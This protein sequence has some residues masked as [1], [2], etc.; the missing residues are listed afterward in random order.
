M[1]GYFE[2]GIA[3]STARTYNAGISKYVDLC[4]K[5]SVS[6]TPTS[7]QLLCRFV[8]S[9]ARDNI[10][11]NTMKVYLA[12]VRQYHIQRGHVMPQ[13]DSMPKLSQILRGIRISRAADPQMIS[14]PLRHP[15]TPE[16]LRQIRQAWEKEGLNSDKVMLWAAFLLAFYCFLRSG[17]VCVAVGEDFD[18]HRDLT[19]Q[20]IAID[21]VSN[22]QMLKVHIKCSKTDPFRAGTDIF[23]ARTKDDLCPVAAMLA[24]LVKRGRTPGPLF[25]FQSGHP[26]S[27]SIFVRSFKQALASAN[28]DPNGFTGH[29]FRIGA[30]TS[31]ANKGMTDTQIKQLGRWKSDAYQRYIRPSP[32]RL[33]TLASSISSH[34]G[35]L[36][37]QG[38]RCAEN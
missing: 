34:S 18:E 16:I 27:R 21:N 29:S 8:T 14:R 12:A 32:Q 13:I 37:E 23:I 22:P 30:A 4:S 10:S 3:P 33:A 31:A 20:D 9:L 28:I 36:Q 35:N 25:R 5:L 1:E 15:V 26:L 2:A 17:E 24:W 19:P 11:H 6:P 38:T 7:E